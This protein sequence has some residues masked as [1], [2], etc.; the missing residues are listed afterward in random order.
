MSSPNYVS[1]VRAALSCGLLFLSAGANRATAQVFTVDTNQSSIAVS[2]SVIGAAIT[3]QGPGSL[4]TVFGGTLQVTL[5]GSTIQFTGQSKIQA[6]T[7]GSWQPK[8]DGTAG[9]EPADFG[10]QATLSLGT[11]K[12]ALRNLELDLISPPIDIT[13]GQ[14]SSTNLT[15]QFATNGLSSF[16]Y[17]VT[18]LLSE[19]GAVALTGYATNKITSLGSLETVGSQQV[20]TIPV[21]TTFYLKLLTANDTIIRLQGKLVAVQSGTS[22]APVVQALTVQN[23]NVLLQWNA[24][25][26]EQVQIQFSTDLLQ[27][28]TNAI[29]TAPAQGTYTWTGILS[30]AVGF[31]RLA[32]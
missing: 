23:N 3:N 30:G 25:Q 13:G 10:A 4:T 29:I 19:H 16:A 26:G 21:D 24:N 5:S 6:E 17:N 8:S 18:G 20:L 22:G 14:F 31:Y 11:G 32:K 7:N 2:G 12:A 9:S 15:F 28:L 1:L 27:W